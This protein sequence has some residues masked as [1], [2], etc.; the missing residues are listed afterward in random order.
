M[1]NG[2]IA[3]NV[4]KQFRIDLSPLLTTS[5]SGDKINTTFIHIMFQIWKYFKVK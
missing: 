2:M 3:E 1:F 5:V 4:F